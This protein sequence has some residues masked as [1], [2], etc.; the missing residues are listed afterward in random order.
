MTSGSS[1]D[2]ERMMPDRAVLGTLF[3]QMRL[4]SQ[5]LRLFSNESSTMYLVVQSYSRLANRA[6]RSLRHVGFRREIGPRLYGLS[7]RARF[8]ANNHIGTS[9]LRKNTCSPLSQ[10]YL[11]SD[12]YC[13]FDS[14]PKL[15]TMG[16]SLRYFPV[17]SIPISSSAAY[18]FLHF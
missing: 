2:V 12:G 15:C 9:F 11:S 7:K 18:L 4:R 10:S 14:E 13:L 5:Q 16:P 6:P 17:N 1:T 3:R 8:S